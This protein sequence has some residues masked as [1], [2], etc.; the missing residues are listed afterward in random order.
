MDHTISAA[1]ANRSF[2]Q[3]LRNVRSGETYVVTAHD[4]PVARIIPWESENV[5]RAGAREAL[6][7]RLESQEVL[8]LERWKRDELYERESV[9]A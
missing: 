4:K 3:L 6:L 8:D 2:S 7:R 9:T 1:E 5:G